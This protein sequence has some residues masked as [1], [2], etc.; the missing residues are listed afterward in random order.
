MPVFASLYKAKT[1]EVPSDSSSAGSGG[2]VSVSATSFASLYEGKMASPPKKGGE[3]E[4]QQLEEEEEEEGGDCGSPKTGEQ[5]RTRLDKERRPTSPV[6]WSGEKDASFISSRTSEAGTSCITTSSEAG[7]STIVARVAGMGINSPT[8]T[9]IAWSESSSESGML[10]DDDLDTKRCFCCLQHKPRSAYSPGQWRMRDV[11]ASRLAATRRKVEANLSESQHVKACL[12]TF[13]EAG[14]PL[15]W[16]KCTECM[17]RTPGYKGP[18]GLT[19]LNNRSSRWLAI[20]QPALDF[21]DDNE[22]EEAILTRK[23]YSMMELRHL[24]NE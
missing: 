11:K 7:T 13:E 10:H 12:D 16:R 23:R 6:E 18:W 9:S 3:E 19:E 1:H 5:Q 2:D 15:A 4:M 17:E 22:E 14:E 24:G 8:A 20:R 21:L